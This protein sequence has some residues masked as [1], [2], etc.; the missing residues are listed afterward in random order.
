MQKKI[1]ESQFLTGLGSDNLVEEFYLAKSHTLRPGTE[2]LECWDRYKIELHIPFLAHEDIDVE[3]VKNKLMVTGNRPVQEPSEP[4]EKN[5]KGIF[6]IP[7]N[8][9]KND[10]VVDF[11]HGKLA[12]TFPKI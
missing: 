11:N 7:N 2:I 5:Y 3:L 1:R 9:S 10:I 6:H 4:N 12:I 8:V